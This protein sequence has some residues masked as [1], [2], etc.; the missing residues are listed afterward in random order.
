MLWIKSSLLLVLSSLPVWGY[1]SF[2]SRTGPVKDP[3]MVAIWQGDVDAV[4]KMLSSVATLDSQYTICP[5]AEATHT[6]PLLNA[7]FAKSE[8]RVGEAHDK[9][10]EFLLSHGASPDYS[11]D[12]FGPLHMAAALDDLPTVHLLL[13]YGAS[14]DL[15]PRDRTPLLVAVQDGSFAV[16]RELIAAGAN[17]DV[18][19]SLGNNLV[20]IAADQHSE[21]LVRLFVQLG[22]DPCV[23][24]KDGNSATYWADFG[25]DDKPRKRAVIA[26]L[27][28]K[29]GLYDWSADVFS[30]SSPP[31]IDTTSWTTP[32][33]AQKKR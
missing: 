11:A 10:V 3:L 26:F 31:L 20:A 1:C 21:E 13:R 29:C 9:M 25:S 14:V 18:H 8:A 30:L 19:D 24:D 2:S 17:I 7:I 15:K 16:V 6:T 4:G 5:G 12:E 33:L 28:S 32:P 23:R 22:I 27:K